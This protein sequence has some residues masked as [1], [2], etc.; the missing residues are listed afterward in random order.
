MTTDSTVELAV[1]GTGPKV[2]TRKRIT[3]Q[4]VDASGNAVADLIDNQQVIGLAD[5]RG[6]L[7]DPQVE[8]LTEL[9]AIHEALDLIAMRLE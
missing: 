3:P 7:V 4:P 2:R 6:N 5:S 1:E 8:V 9:R